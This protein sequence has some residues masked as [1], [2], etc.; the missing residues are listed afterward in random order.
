MDLEILK[1]KL[2]SYRREG[3]RVTKVSDELL[4]EILGAWENWTCS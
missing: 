1:K 3:G 2:S 4:L